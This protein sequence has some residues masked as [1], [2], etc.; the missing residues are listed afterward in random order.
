MENSSSPAFN[1]PTAIEGCSWL[2]F[3]GLHFRVPLLRL[4]SGALVL[5]SL[6][7]EP[8]VYDLEVPVINP[9]APLISNLGW[10]G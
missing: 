3:L 5:I 10:C 1:C 8:V 7:C 6:S 4:A 2:A 9:F